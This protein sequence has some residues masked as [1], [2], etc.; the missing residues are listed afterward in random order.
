MAVGRVH[1]SLPAL[2]AILS[3]LEKQT[4]RLGKHMNEIFSKEG[5]WEGRNFVMIIQL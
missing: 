4:D 1:Q 3:Y 5:G 2:A